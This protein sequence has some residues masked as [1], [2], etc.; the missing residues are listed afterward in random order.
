M[1]EKIEKAFATAN[2]M[3]TLSNQRRIILEEFN[4]KLIYYV[5]GATFKITP[6]LITF[7]KMLSER[8][9]DVILV[10]SNNLPVK[11]ENPQ[12]FLGDIMAVYD[13]AATEYHQKYSSI[14]TKRKIADIIEL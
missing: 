11:I 9:G 7:V 10:D 13:S 5:A 4:Q 14:K 2:F 1:D 3:A 8:S 6:Q 12:Q